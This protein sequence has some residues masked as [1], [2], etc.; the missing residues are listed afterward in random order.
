MRGFRRLL[1]P[2]KPPGAPGRA[3]CV[4]FASVTVTVTVTIATATPLFAFGPL[5]AAGGA[6]QFPVSNLVEPK[7]TPTPTPRPTPAPE[8]SA[9]P[10]GRSERRIPGSAVERE[11]RVGLPVE[12]A[13]LDLFQGASRDRLV[14]Y[15]D[16]TVSLAETRHGDLRERR[17]TIS[18]EERKL[19]SN[20]LAEA[21]T[22]PRDWNPRRPTE[23]GPG[24]RRGEISVTLPGMEPR[25]FAFDD[26]LALPFGYGRVRGA[27][28]DL[29]GRFRKAEEAGPV[30]WDPK[31]VKE[32]TLLQRRDDGKWFRVVRDDRLSPYLEIV[33]DAGP[34]LERMFLTRREVP[35][36]FEPPRGVEGS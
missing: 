35:R 31:G 23:D 26:L 25:R 17:R 34:R 7:T 2:W 28:E 30:P 12:I 18:V 6:G 8:E 33:E 10:G 4:L 24:R 1:S 32:G 9:W 15:D 13:S 11:G 22:V 20:V 5:P 36:F 3:T 29:L 14:L 21:S 27:L 16:G 19:V